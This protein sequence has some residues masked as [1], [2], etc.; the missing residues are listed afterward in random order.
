MN[1]ERQRPG[2]TYLITFACY[3]A[4][5]HGEEGAIDREHN[6]PGTPVLAAN[7]AFVKRSLADMTQ[8]PYELDATRRAPTMQGIQHV[9]KRRGWGLIA[10]HVRTN[11]VH[12]IVNADRS[13]ENVMTALKA[14][15]SRFLNEAGLE[16]KDRRRWARPGSTRYLGTHE[17]IERAIDYVVNRQGEPMEV[18]CCER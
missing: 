5:L 13:P 12:V 8:P 14:Y 7:P 10:A 1:R 6:V 18:Y 16:S 2:K 11:H 15:A 17:A 3:G 4:H 9:C